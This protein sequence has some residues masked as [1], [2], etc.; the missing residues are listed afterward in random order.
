M[1]YRIILSFAIG[2]LIFG[3]FGCN[4]GHKVTLS[5]VS[6]PARATIEKLTAS[7][8]IK[9]IEKET[10][11]GKTI[12]DIEARVKGKDVEYDI[13]EDGEILT[14]EESIPYDSLPDAVKQTAEKYFGFT[15]G[16]KGG[17]RPPAE[18]VRSRTGEPVG[19]HAHLADG[20]GHEDPL[21]PGRGQLPRR[22]DAHQGRRAAPP[23]GR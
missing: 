2:S 3:T 1:R 15:E 6:E 23:A 20:D 18:R 14:S 19:S 11:N 4:F 12:Y 16:L 22:R 21:A 17:R 8:E 13:A 5:K 9:K 7:G 10:S